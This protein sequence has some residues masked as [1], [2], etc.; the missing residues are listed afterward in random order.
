MYLVKN[1]WMGSLLMGRET[2]CAEIADLISLSLFNFWKCGKNRNDVLTKNPRNNV[3]IRKI[4]SFKVFPLFVLFLVSNFSMWAFASIFNEF[5]VLSVFDA[6]ESRK[7]KQI[8][9]TVL[10]VGG[11]QLGK[12]KKKWGGKGG[13]WWK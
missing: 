3:I 7:N 1:L 9:E 11:S 6:D 4:R 5:C 10:M 8:F 2:L 12:L 13:R